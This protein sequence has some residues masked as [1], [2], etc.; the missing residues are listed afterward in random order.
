QG[1]AAVAGFAGCG[2]LLA[3]AWLTLGAPLVALAQAVGT[4]G[5]ALLLARAT[6][7]LGPDDL[8]DSADRPVPALRVVIALLCATV[9]LAL[10][11]GLAATALALTLLL[12][13]RAAA[14][15]GR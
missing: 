7:R 15:P 6:R 14:S 1:L 4:A 2:L 11:A 10:A 3:L 8:A 12:R 9:A 13:L 5:A